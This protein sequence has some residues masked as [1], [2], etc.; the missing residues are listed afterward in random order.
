MILRLLAAGDKRLSTGKTQAKAP[1][2]L[3]LGILIAALLIPAGLIAQVV[4]RNPQSPDYQEQLGLA[5]PM[6]DGVRLAADLFLPHGG[7]RRS[8][9]LVRTPYNRKTPVM[10]GYRFF[11]RRGYAVL[12][13]DVRGRYASQGAFGT[14]AQE[15]PDG[16]D[17]VNWIAEQSWSNGR[18]AMVGNSYSGLVQ[19]WAA[20]QDNPHLMAISPLCSGD[21]EYMDRFYS[22]GGALQIGHRLLWLAENLT[23]PSHVRPLFASYIDHLPLRTASVRGHTL[24]DSSGPSASRWDRFEDV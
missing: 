19:W 21:D 2:P 15:G 13:E 14:T 10:I 9:V 23:P 8:T 17:T 24:C 3:R 22:A 4:A 1:V 12:I 7:G 16:S 20:I 18:V 5:I 11:T 6:R